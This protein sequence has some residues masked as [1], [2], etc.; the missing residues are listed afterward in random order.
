[1]A[2][3]SILPP[4]RSAEWKDALAQA[5][6]CDFYHLPEYHALAESQGEGQAN[7]FLYTEGG[8]IIALPLLLRAVEAV[9]GLAGV[10]QGWWDATSVYGYVGPVASRE[11]VP[12][13]VVKNFHTA[14]SKALT[15]QN[16]V[17]VFSRLHPLMPQ[18]RLLANFGSYQPL[19]QTVSIDLTLPSDAQYELYRKSTRY[20]IRKLRRMGMV[21]VHDENRLYLPE[22][23]D[24]YYETMHRVNAQASYFFPRT[25]FDRLMSALGSR[26]QL[27]VCTLDGE[28]TCGALFALFD[29]IVQFHLAATKTEY[30]KLA[31][32]KL[33]LDTAR[34]W[35]TERKA[36]VLHL[37]GGVNFRA[38]SL[39]NFKAGFS[40]RRHDYAVWHHVILPDIYE[41]LRV[42]KERWC[43]KNGLDSPSPE[44]FPA[45]R[46][47][48]DHDMAQA[49]HSQHSATGSARFQSASSEQTR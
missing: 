3:L 40:D 27:F 22:F 9:P 8:Y 23:V 35:A 21:C 5:V 49:P 6:Q 30:L 4:E 18:D 48:H 31:P 32:M 46:S 43:Q 7:L 39:F 13:L 2:S 16:V 34:Q 11:Y 42:E 29:G 47:A 19:G 10:G 33:M 25:Y 44:Y 14:L 45:Y 26:I 1:M 20:D 41:A 38:D 17:A 36:T 12:G 15:D 28:M 24:L 37:G